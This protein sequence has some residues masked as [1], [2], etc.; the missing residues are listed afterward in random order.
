MRSPLL[1]EVTLEGQSASTIMDLVRELRENGLVQGTDFDFA[2]H[3]ELFDEF[4]GRSKHTIFFFHNE[5]TAS[6]FSLKHK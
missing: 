3:P 4:S 1:I 2:F 6:W 5:K